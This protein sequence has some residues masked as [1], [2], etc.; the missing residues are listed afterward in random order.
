M[1]WSHASFSKF[2]VVVLTW[3]A[4]LGETVSISREAISL[5]DSGER[6]VAFVSLGF[7][8]RVTVALRGFLVELIGSANA[9]AAAGVG[10]IGGGAAG[11]AGFACARFLGGVDGACCSS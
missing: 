10:V 2:S 8:S 4:L 3:G 11:V 1:R 6:S 7:A 5:D 9:P